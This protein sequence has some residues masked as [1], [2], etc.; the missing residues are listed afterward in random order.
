DHPVHDEPG[1]GFDEVWHRA[2]AIL[3]RDGRFRNFLVTDAAQL[4]ALTATGYFVVHAM[5]KF[6]LPLSSAGTFTMIGM[7]GMMTANVAGGY[8]ADHYGNKL[9]LMLLLGSMATASLL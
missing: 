8:L 5:E 6:H 7:S 9:M 1:I 3:R 2:V 4:V